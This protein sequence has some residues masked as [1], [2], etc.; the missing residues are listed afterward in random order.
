M[1]RST[2]FG[3]TTKA[4]GSDLSTPNRSPIFWNGST[5]TIPG[6]G[7][8]ST[9]LSTTCPSSPKDTNTIPTWSAGNAFRT[10]R[11]AGND[12]TQG[13]HQVAKNETTRAWFSFLARCFSKDQGS[14]LSVQPPNPGMTDPTW[15]DPEAATILDTA[16]P[17]SSAPRDGGATAMANT[18][19]PAASRRGARVGHVVGNF[20][21]PE[22][23]PI[24]R[25]SVP[26]APF[27]L[28]ALFVSHCMFPGESGGPPRSQGMPRWSFPSKDAGCSS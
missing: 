23:Y 20:T 22:V 6:T 5:S 4:R 9:K 28:L 11:S 26:A 17:A 12:F 24:T 7:F 25:A 21:G 1:A 2:P 15:S 3:S 13:W 19:S 10:W 16:G 8:F 18:T 14:P 27:D